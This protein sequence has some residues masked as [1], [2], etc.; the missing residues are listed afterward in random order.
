MYAVAVKMSPELG[1]GLGGRITFVGTRVTGAGAGLGRTGLGVLP[2][3]VL[4]DAAGDSVGAGGNDGP[5]VIGEGV[6]CARDGR[7]KW[8]GRVAVPAGCLAHCTGT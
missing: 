7:E 5:V 8:V 2:L 1:L 3:T 4:T 6:A